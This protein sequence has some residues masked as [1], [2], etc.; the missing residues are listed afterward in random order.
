MK[1]YIYHNS[2]LRKSEAE[3]LERLTAI[4]KHFEEYDLDIN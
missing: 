4:Q 3:N 2:R 1:N